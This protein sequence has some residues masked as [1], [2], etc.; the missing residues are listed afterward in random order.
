MPQRVCLA[1]R[2]LVI[3][4]FAFRYW[5][6][7]YRPFEKT[8]LTWSIWLS[9][10]CFVGGA[11]MTTIWPQYYPHFLR[12]SLIGGISLLTVLIATRVTLAHGDEGKGLEKTWRGIIIF[13][14]LMIVAALTRATAILLPEHYLRHLGYAAITW[15]FGFAIWAV[16]MV[17]RMAFRGR[18]RRL[19]SN[20]K[21]R[22][23]S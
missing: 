18:T 11:A 1:L 8:Y 16:A 14:A 17:P 12:I 22:H 9:C 10:W 19:R 7:Q 3:F 2:T 15:T 21:P 23:I 20:D 5:R 6:L 13:S 4:F